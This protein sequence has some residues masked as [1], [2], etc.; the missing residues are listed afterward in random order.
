[1]E[2]AAIMTQAAPA[3]DDSAMVDGESEG[4]RAIRVDGDAAADTPAVVHG[5]LF[6]PFHLPHTGTSHTDGERAA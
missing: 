1:M 3:S 6:E 5:L 2:L 4:E